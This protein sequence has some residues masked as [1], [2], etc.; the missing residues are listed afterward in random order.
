MVRQF[1]QWN[2]QG[3]IVGRERRNTRR[4]LR[5]SPWM[6]RRPSSTQG[7]ALTFIRRRGYIATIAKYGCIPGL[8]KADISPR[9]N[10]RRPICRSYAQGL[11]AAG[12]SIG[13]HISLIDVL[14]YI[15]AVLSAQKLEVADSCRS[16]PC[17]MWYIMVASQRTIGVDSTS[18]L[19]V[20]HTER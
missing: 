11:K 12:E 19:T 17:G 3:R 16:R 9:R 6:A 20:D 7:S 4:G 18:L 2:L 14:N 15:C 1:Q 10:L 13:E 8:R 5:S